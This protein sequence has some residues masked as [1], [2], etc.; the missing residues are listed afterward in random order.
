MRQN[1]NLK[2]VQKEIYNIQSII[3]LSLKLFF[4]LNWIGGGGGGIPFNKPLEG[5]KGGGGIPL[6]GGGGGEGIPL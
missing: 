1:I 4:S 5:G 3:F 6:E 2:I